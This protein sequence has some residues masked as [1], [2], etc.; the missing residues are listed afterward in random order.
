MN[1]KLLSILLSSTIPI[2]ISS[3]CS[4]AYESQS[5]PQSESDFYNSLSKAIKNAENLKKT[6][7]KNTP[8]KENDTT[9][10]N[11]NPSDFKSNTLSEDNIQ[12]KT[13]KTLESDKNLQGTTSPKVAQ[14]EKPISV[15]SNKTNTPQIQ[16]AEGLRI[17]HWN[18]LNYPNKQPQTNEFK[19]S[20]ISK[21]LSEI[22]PDVIGLTE[23]NNG[24][25]EAVSLIVDKLNLLAN[26]KRHYQM[27]YQPKSDYNEDSSKDVQESV[28]I[29]YDTNKLSPIPFSDGTTQKSFKGEI[30]LPFKNEDYVTS[31]VRPPFGVMFN[32][33]GTEKSFTTIF[34]HF[35]SPGKKKGIEKGFNDLNHNLK[36]FNGAIGYQEGVEAYHLDKVFDFF[37]QAGAKNIVFGGD[38]NIPV[39]SSDLFINLVTKGYLSGWS[40][41]QES[42]TSL[43]M[44]A[45]LREA[46]LAQN[47]NDAYAQPYDRMFYDKDNFDQ[48]PKN[49]DL[50]KYDIFKNYIENQEF[51]NY[52]NN[53]YLRLFNVKLNKGKKADK[54]S[55]SIWY[56]LR[57][58]VS[59]HLPVWLSLSFKN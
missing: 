37:K 17:A 50:F 5:S 29:L 25:Y 9:P 1:F 20:I 54:N 7:N 2:A 48:D 45:R 47:Y 36:L 13:K 40:D 43:R 35:D 4:S 18:I 33:N 57:Y 31:Y 52:V 42:S 46:T 34:D 16:E 21:I 44:P 24:S 19:V 10:I 12:N 30:D 22:N 59:D 38:T 49:R 56:V 28:V 11:P 23:I 26:S 8:S 3:S 51:Q 39:D 14:T 27:I 55:N 41:N 53:E 58:I 15:E 32:V 6:I